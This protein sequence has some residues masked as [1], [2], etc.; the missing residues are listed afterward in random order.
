MFP[1]FSALAKFT[2]RE[3]RIG[4]LINVIH[5]SSR[6]INTT[7]TITWP[8]VK[9]IMERSEEENCNEGASPSLSRWLGLRPNFQHS[10]FVSNCH[11]IHS[12]SDENRKL[13]YDLRKFHH[14]LQFQLRWAPQPMSNP[15]DKNNHENARKYRKQCNKMASYRSMY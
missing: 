10:M 1:P 11:Q 8:S 14:C 5:K 9:A 15:S 4:M 7:T 3:K 6:A 13:I 2:D 12:K